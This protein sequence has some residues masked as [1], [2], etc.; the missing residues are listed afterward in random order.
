MNKGMI[1]SILHDMSRADVQNWKNRLDKEGT[2]YANEEAY[3]GSSD[4]IDKLLNCDALDVLDVPQYGDWYEIDEEDRDDFRN[5]EMKEYIT[6]D[7]PRDEAE[8][9][10]AWCEY[11]DSAVGGTISGL[12]DLI[13]VRLDDKDLTIDEAT[14]KGVTFQAFKFE[15]A[16]KTFRDCEDSDVAQEVFNTFRSSPIALLAT[17]DNTSN[18]A[19]RGCAS[20]DEVKQ[21]QFIAARD[22]L[23]NDGEL[24]F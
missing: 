6:S 2:H 3:C 21:W 7:S 22:F 16:L 24:S 18:Y 4:I 17:L 10:P 9:Y 8:E 1:E 19:V 23:D 12:L 15:D 14:N 20:Y 11:C 5:N 13:G